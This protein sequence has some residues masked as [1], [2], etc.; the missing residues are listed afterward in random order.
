MTLEDKIAKALMAKHAKVLRGSGW[1]CETDDFTV[2]EPEEINYKSA[3][4]RIGGAEIT[5]KVA[6]DQELQVKGL[7]GH[8]ELGPYEGMI[9]PYYE[10]G[11]QR[12]SFH[13]DRVKFPIDMIFVGS[14]SRVTKIV[15]NI[16]PGT[17]G[18]WGMPHISAVI[19]VNGGFCAA[20]GISVGAEVG[21]FE[22]KTAQQD[23]IVPPGIRVRVYKPTQDWAGIGYN[24]WMIVSAEGSESGVGD[25][26]DAA[27]SDFL[28]TTHG[29][30]PRG[31]AND[32]GLALLIKDLKTKNTGPRLASNDS[33]AAQSQAMCQE[34]GSTDMGP[35]PR[36][37]QQCGARLFAGP[38][39]PA[40]LPAS[41]SQMVEMD[42]IMQTMPEYNPHLFPGID[43]GSSGGKENLQM[44]VLDDSDVAPQLRDRM[45]NVDEYRQ[46]PEEAH[47]ATIG[48]AASRWAE[49]IRAT[50][51]AAIKDAILYAWG[52][53]KQTSVDN[54]P[55]MFDAEPG[56]VLEQVLEAETMAYTLMSFAD[57]DGVA[58]IGIEAQSEYR[59]G[60]NI[61]ASPVDSWDAD[62]AASALIDDISMAAAQAVYSPDVIPGADVVDPNEFEIQ[63]MIDELDLEIRIAQETFPSYTRKDIN[64]KMV[65][66][67]DTPGRFKDRD[68]LD[69]VLD[70][71]PMDGNR[72]EQEIGY[73]QGSPD[74]MGGPMDPATRPL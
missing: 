59:G 13:M 46:W 72:F 38:A 73:D 47:D 60:E 21:Q 22:N 54:A 51:A 16:E 67:N 7:N 43:E 44:D 19:E 25:T 66:P 71:Q 57:S 56:S 49:S 33:K 27:M 64:P 62:A 23:T 12:V 65:T 6:D 18:Q 3:K 11:G 37:C 53:M 45:L 55:I 58:Q 42:S 69:E 4:L 2:E 35:D 63:G 39:K 50:D 48:Q 17:P 34:C 61:Y 70:T 32:D 15:E 31:P 52:T 40:K 30:Q 24:H 10:S 1:F 29:Q 36:F 5:C 74:E 28:K 14:D 68:T 8:A 41:P 9:F 26:Y 20:H